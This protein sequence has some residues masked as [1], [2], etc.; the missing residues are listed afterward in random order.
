MGSRGAAPVKRI[1]S[2]QKSKVGSDI[3]AELRAQ[4]ESTRGGRKRGLLSAEQEA[5]EGPQTD[6]P[7]TFAEQQ[8]RGG[9]AATHAARADIG[10]AN[11][12]VSAANA[13]RAEEQGREDKL[14]KKR[15]GQ[16]QSRKA[17]PGRSAALI[18]GKQKLIT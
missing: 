10:A 15:V 17:R 5:L 9:A 4:I 13:L 14:L 11:Q 18:G 8:A 7:T 6:V 1:G 2:E 3:Q 16:I 12:A